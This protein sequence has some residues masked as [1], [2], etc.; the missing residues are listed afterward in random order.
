[1]AKP[2]STAPKFKHAA[3]CLCQ[4]LALAGYP[5]PQKGSLQSGLEFLPSGSKGRH[6]R[7]FCWVA[8]STFPGAGGFLPLSIT[9]KSFRAGYFSWELHAALIAQKSISEHCFPHIVPWLSTF[10]NSFLPHPPLA[11]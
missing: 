7:R 5:S 6:F 9:T 11:G 1:M 2:S 4:V 3:R 8:L 10:P